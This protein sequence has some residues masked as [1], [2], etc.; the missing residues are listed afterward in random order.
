MRTSPWRLLVYG[1]VVGLG[2]LFALPN[3]LT[4]D[5]AARLPGFLPSRQV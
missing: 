3:I 1:L 4:K 5:Q 2:L